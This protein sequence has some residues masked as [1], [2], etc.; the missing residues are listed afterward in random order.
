M[1]SFRHDSNALT[2]HH[3]IEKLSPRRREVLE[4]ISKGLT[5]DDIAS[6]L[7]VSPGTVRIHVAGLLSE[8]QVANRTEAAAAYFEWKSTTVQLTK[9]LE[10]PAIA[11]LA[12]DALDRVKNGALLA[13]AMTQD[14]ST[15]FARW[16]WFPVV[17]AAHTRTSQ[18][19]TS[20]PRELG[21]ALG[22]RFLV[23]GSLRAGKGSWRL[24]VRMDDAEDGRCLWAER[25]E[26]PSGE[27]FDVQDQVCETIVATAY[28]VLVKGLSSRVGA[29]RHPEGLDAWALA[30]EGMLLHAARAPE[31]N[32]LARSRFVAALEHDPDL[33]LAHFGLGLC[34]YDKLLNQWESND[35]AAD[36]L[37]ASAQRCVELAPHAAEGYFLLGRYYQARGKHEQAL[38]ILEMA[39]ARNPSAAMAH[40]LLAQLLAMKGHYDEGL[41]RMRHAVRLSPRSY[42]AGLGVVHFL[43]NEQQDALEHCETA[44][45]VRP[46]YAFARVLAVAS[47]W[48][49]G[50][51]ERAR[52]H[53][54]ALRAQHPAFSSTKFLTTF[55][56][57]HVWHERIA[58]AL[59]ALGE[60]Y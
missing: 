16:C 43:R 40:A 38:P 34:Q 44:L 49:L 48:W 58:K 4:L 1:A 15:L 33:P 54:R 52:V 27:L 14:L 45:A 12:F 47:A 23:G 36:T 42:V 10:R 20:S 51:I 30:H 59:E 5:N 22:A 31:S 35:A 28:D 57:G 25:F 26:F 39:V 32:A 11:V 41:T 56:N 3:F 17:T 50:D 6:I 46:D 7:C 60:L 29:H 13:A 19:R 18:S 21:C 53:A 8:L 2:P 24:A 9:V 37:L 55:G